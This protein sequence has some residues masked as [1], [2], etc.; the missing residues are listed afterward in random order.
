MA[1]AIVRVA[2]LYLKY[3]QKQNS[4]PSFDLPPESLII[5]T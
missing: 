5:I 2:Q 4:W 3:K 1:Y